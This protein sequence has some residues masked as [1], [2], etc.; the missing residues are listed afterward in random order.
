MSNLK[1]KDI[2]FVQSSRY[3]PTNQNIHSPTYLDY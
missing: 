1:V 2:H 3:A